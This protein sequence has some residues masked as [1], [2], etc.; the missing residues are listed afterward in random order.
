[1]PDIASYPKVYAIGHAAIA[2][3]FL[4]PILVEEKIDGSQFS[5]SITDGHLAFRSRGAEIIS[6]APEKMFEIGVKNV[7]EISNLLHPEWTYRAEYLSRPKHNALQY[8]RIPTRNLIL[9]DINVGDEQYLSRPEKEKEAIRLGLETVP[10][11]FSGTIGLPETILSFLE[12]ESC[13]GGTKIEGVVIKNYS[14][15]GKD[16]KALMGKFVR[17]EFKETLTKEW[18]ASN[19]GIGDIIECLIITL[20]TEARWKKAIQ[21][22]QERGQLLND[23]KDI[24]QLILEVRRDIQEEEI[25]YISKKLGEFAISKIARACSA[26]LPEWYKEQLLRSAFPAT[27]IGLDDTQ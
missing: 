8:A 13:L 25:E 24:G 3:I 11:M 1:M 21:H 10:I 12:S 15:F 26:G 22:L 4:D 23:P 5:F 27:K 9:F 18:K 17:E 16:K 7:K 14:R 6:D 19:P 20:K 2:D